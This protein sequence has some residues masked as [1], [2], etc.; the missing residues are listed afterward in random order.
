LTNTLRKRFKGNETAVDE[1]LAVY[2]DPQLTQVVPDVRLRAS[3]AHLKGTSGEPAIDAIKTVYNNV[4]FMD[5]LDQGLLAYVSIPVGQKPEIKV[6]SLYQH[7]DERRFSSILAHESMHED[8]QVAA[9]EEEINNS[10]DPIV[11]GEQ[12][13]TD[14]TLAHSGTELSRRLNTKLMARLNSRGKD[15][16][17]RTYEAQGNVF[18]GGRPLDC[19]AHAFEGTPDNTTTP[20]N[21]TLQAIVKQVTNVSMDHPDFDRTTL[22]VI[23]HHQTALSPEDIVNVAEQA[24]KLNTTC[25]PPN[26]A[27]TNATD[28]PEPHQGTDDPPATSGAS[29]TAAPPGWLAMLTAPVALAVNWVRGREDRPV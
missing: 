12:L 18:P 10:L 9:L 7:E 28:P 24:L 25:T 21:P 1:G 20:G 2:T 17:L 22:D 26:N 19:F 13:K 5:N 14:P 29:P 16:G 8:D 23:D 15:G 3:V 11:Y 6:N 27:T 4:E